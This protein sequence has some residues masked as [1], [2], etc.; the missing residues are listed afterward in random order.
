LLHRLPRIALQFAE[1][2]QAV[3]IENDFLAHGGI[4]EPDSPNVAP[5][6]SME[7]GFLAATAYPCRFSAF[8][9]EPPP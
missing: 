7:E 1:D 3:A 2:A 9:H 6:R 8:T 4:R 5:V